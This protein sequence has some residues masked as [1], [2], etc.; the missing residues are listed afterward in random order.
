MTT[1][2]LQESASLVG[3]VWGGHCPICQEK[4][5]MLLNTSG[6]WECPS[7]GLQIESFP[8]GEIT[9][10]KNY[11]RGIF[12]RIRGRVHSADESR[13]SP[14]GPIKIDLRFQRRP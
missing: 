12:V 1:R 5:E 14:Y 3:E 8:V 4:R 6:A 9:V 13:Y 11:G 10:L 7:C 2:T